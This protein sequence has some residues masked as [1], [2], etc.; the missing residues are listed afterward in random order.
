MVRIALYAGLSR[1]I[2]VCIRA[3]RM[4]G[5]SCEFVAMMQTAEPGHGD[6]R[7]VLILSSGYRSTSRSLL[8]QP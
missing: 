7:G 5:S 6:D 1:A 4:I 8:L 2:R 3:S